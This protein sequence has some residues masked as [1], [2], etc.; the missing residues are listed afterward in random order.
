MR[1]KA[2]IITELEDKLKTKA[3]ESVT[4]RLLE[5]LYQVMHPWTRALLT[6]CNKI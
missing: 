4:N 1:T 6:S 2:E 5:E 3:S